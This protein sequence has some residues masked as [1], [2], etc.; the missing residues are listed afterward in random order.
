MDLG[1]KN[2]NKY[3]P[4]KFYNSSAYNLVPNFCTMGTE[5]FPWHIGRRVV[6]STNLLLVP[7]SEW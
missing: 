1:H 3:D 7:E 2:K 6:L 4:Y 5:Y